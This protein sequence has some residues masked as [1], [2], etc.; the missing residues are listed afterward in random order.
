MYFSFS[1][2]FLVFVNAVSAQWKPHYVSGHEGIVH[3]F[4]W[5]YNDIANECE[6]FLG[7]KG[8]AGVQIS[9]VQENVII[10]GRPWWERYQPISYLLTTRSGDEAAFKDMTRRCNIVGIRIYVDI[11]LNHMTQDHSINIGTGGSTA[12]P[13][14][15]EYYS[16]PY[17]RSDFHAPCSINDYQNATNVRNCELYSLHD[18]DQK[19]THVRNEI[20]NLM[21]KLIEAGVAG[22]RIDAAK[23]MWPRDLMAIFCSLNNLNTNHGFRLGSRPFIY[24]EVIDNGGE[25]ISNTEY[26]PL[27]RVTEF[28]HSLKI[29]DAFTGKIQ[30]KNL[31]NW[32]LKWG[33]LPS[34]YAFVFVDNHDNQR[35]HGSGGEI[36]TYKNPRKYKMAVAF[37]LTQTYGIPRVMSSFAFDNTDAGPPADEL[38][39]IISPIFN[40]DLSCANGWVCEHRWHQIYSMINFRNV[41]TGTAISNWWDN[42][43]NQISFCRGNSGFIAINADS[44]SLQ[45]NLQTCLPAGIYC[46]VISGNVE[47][48]R[49][50]GKTVIVNDCGMAYIEILTN[51]DDGVLALHVNARVRVE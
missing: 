45:V 50:T 19:N 1:L 47:K 11:L 30:L 48:R 7:P 21:N 43:S 12:D 32:G 10:D 46:D 6:T 40:P 26:T 51:D 23:H 31:T 39:N 14:S 33:F 16:V 36:L 15:R 20:V 25:A 44:W 9:P 3:L 28:K 5:K 34:K 24:Q 35:G 41:V 4:E 17:S 27:G 8:Y 18:L 42:G 37:M 49:C 29:S 22:F 13:I 2:L 38:G